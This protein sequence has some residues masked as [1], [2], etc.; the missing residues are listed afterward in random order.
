M[1]GVFRFCFGLSPSIKEV[2]PSVC[3]F[4]PLCPACHPPTYFWL[5][6]SMSQEADA[7]GGEA[8]FQGH[9]RNL[10]ARGS[11]SQVFLRLHL[12]CNLTLVCSSL[13][14]R[15]V[16]G[17]LSKLNNPESE[18]A[19]AVGGPA[20]GSVGF[21][22][23]PAEGRRCAGRPAQAESANLEFEAEGSFYQM[24]SQAE[25]QHVNTRVELL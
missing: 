18:A 2:Y 16:M 22:G 5:L 1:F 17:T 10:G 13:V 19:V 23:K 6:E 14:P 8:V 24:K 9:R 12:G 25:S 11:G 7:V 21:T 4:Q 20:S 3:W 15:P